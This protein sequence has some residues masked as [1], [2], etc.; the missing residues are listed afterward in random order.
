MKFGINRFVGLWES[1]DGYRL[2]IAK[3]SDTS[4]MISFYDPSG[5]PVLR[6]YFNDKPTIKMPASYDGVYA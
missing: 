4:A 2:D 6:P 5:K 3:I 1:E